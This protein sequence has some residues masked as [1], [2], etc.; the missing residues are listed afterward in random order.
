[1]F[2]YSV[3]IKYG[4]ALGMAWVV[5]RFVYAVGYAYDSFVGREIGVLLGSLSSWPLLL[6]TLYNALTSAQFREI[7]HLFCNCH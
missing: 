4:F 2:T 6:G 1:M 5:S 3:S 7:L